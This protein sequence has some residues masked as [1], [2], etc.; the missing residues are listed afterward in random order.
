MREGSR[1]LE[2]EEGEGDDDEGGRS[3]I[4]IP[5][6][7]VRPRVLFLMAVA[8][9]TPGARVGGAPVFSA[10]RVSAERFSRVLR[11]GNDG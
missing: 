1:G 3:V 11:P 8:T 7:D 5:T 9:F 6:S 10:H 2:E 4:R